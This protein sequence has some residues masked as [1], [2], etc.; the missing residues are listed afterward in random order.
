[1][2]KDHVPQDQGM[3]GGEKELCYAVDEQGKYVTVQSLGWEVKEIAIAQAWDLIHEQVAQAKEKVR[4]GEL[5]PLA[6]YMAKNQMSAGLLAKYAGI[7]RW[8]VKRHLRPAVFKKLSASV[9]QRYADVFKISVE[10][11]EF[12]DE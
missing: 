5:S 1:M 7:W 4:K 8:R 11:L 2:D 3:L 10:R 9:R 12:M 6:Y